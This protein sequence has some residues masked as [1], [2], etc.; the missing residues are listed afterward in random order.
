MKK[1]DLYEDLTDKLHRRKYIPIVQSVETKKNKEVVS[2]ILQKVK[3][4]KYKAVHD[5]SMEELQNNIKTNGLD[6]KNL[7]YL[8]SYVVHGKTKFSA[9]F[10]FEKN[11]GWLLLNDVTP[12][13]VEMKTMELQT[14]GYTPQIIVGYEQEGKPRFATLW[15]RYG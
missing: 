7:I 4:N 2:F 5:L 8:D 1:L 15:K 6:N 10:S 13:Q 14:S 11:N 3:R 9:I 12:E